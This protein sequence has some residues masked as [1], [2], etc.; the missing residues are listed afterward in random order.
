MDGWM[1]SSGELRYFFCDRRRFEVPDTV[2]ERAQMGGP[3]GPLADPQ[4][5][6]LW[7]NLTALM[8]Q[9]TLLAPSIQCSHGIFER[10]FPPFLVSD[11]FSFQSLARWKSSEFS[12]LIL[13]FPEASLCH[14]IVPAFTQM[15]IFS[16]TMPSEKGLAEVPTSS[17][18][19]G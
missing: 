4:A 8:L 9:E 14:A 7:V 6:S 10:K 1:E 2:K 19:C 18:M 11:S 16:L 5:A 17:R 15:G 12:P 13:A 3:L